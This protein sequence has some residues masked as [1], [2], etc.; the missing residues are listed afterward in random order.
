MCFFVELGVFRALNLTCV[1]CLRIM[2]M[3]GELL[4][5]IVTSAAVSGAGSPCV[6]RDSM[7]FFVK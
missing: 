3:A 1:L 7:T 6:G 4:P 5:Q 2:V